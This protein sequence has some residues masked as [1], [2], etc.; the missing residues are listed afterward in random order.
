MKQF[1]LLAIAAFLVGAVNAQQVTPV[2]AT[3]QKQEVKDINKVL[4]F[5]N[6]NYS[7][8]KLAQGKPV[9]FDLE[10]K[11]I[12][13][14]SVRIENV[15]VQCGC[16]TPKWQPGPYAPGQSFKVT[17]GYNNA[18]AGAFSKTV[19]IYFSGG[20]TKTVTFSGETFAAPQNAAPE[21][22]GLGKIKP[23]K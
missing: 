22:N 6:D 1:T 3:E 23:G 2:P 5:K 13:T 10:V 17:L 9:E 14:D 4:S 18:T 19:T 21:N 16:T 8:G 12:S 15:Q 20:L 7:F 11:N